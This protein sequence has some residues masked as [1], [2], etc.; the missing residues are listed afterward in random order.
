MKKVAAGRAGAAVK[1]EKLK[2]KLLDDL[3]K[4]KAVKDD[5]KLPEKPTEKPAKPPAKPT[6]K[7]G[8]RG[9]F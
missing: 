6:E 8:R 3:R 1:T 2:E 7:P 5:E 4:M 9:L